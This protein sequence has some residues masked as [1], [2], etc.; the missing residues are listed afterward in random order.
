MGEVF[1]GCAESVGVVKK[2]RNHKLTIHHILCR[3]K[4]GDDHPKNI[5][6]ISR[7]QHQFYHTLFKNHTPE[8]ILQE[9]RIIYDNIFLHYD[10]KVAW[11]QVF[12][13]IGP[14]L[15][16]KALFEE[17]GFSQYFDQKVNTAR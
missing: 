13:D 4:G 3:S 1:D 14:T 9:I 2:K 10:L 5:L 15:A 8:E 11:R 6:K 17:W 16:M 12:G 7:S